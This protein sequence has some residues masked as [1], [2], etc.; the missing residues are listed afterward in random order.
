LDIKRKNIIVPI[1]NSFKEKMVQSFQKV[2]DFE[3][4]RVDDSIPRTYDGINYIFI[5]H[6]N[7]KEITATVKDI[8][9][10]QKFYCIVPADSFEN[11]IVKT[12][13]RIIADIKSKS[14][15]EIKYDIYK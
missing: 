7:D 6:L 4:K 5:I 2:I 11:E 9:R 8:R 12:N 13:L 14:F 1:S 15:E 3:N 10:E